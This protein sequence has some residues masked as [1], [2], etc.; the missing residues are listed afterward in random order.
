MP[1][2]NKT[3]VCILRDTLEFNINVIFRKKVIVVIL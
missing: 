2:V 1:F 3:D